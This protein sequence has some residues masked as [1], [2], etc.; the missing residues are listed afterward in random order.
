[1]A[2]SKRIEAQ[3][4]QELL[5]PRRFGDRMRLMKRPVQIV[6]HKGYTEKRIMQPIGY[7]TPNEKEESYYQSIN[8][9]AKLTA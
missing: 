8:N 1:L 9:T 4:E 2:C 5:A 7:I 3:G 6:S